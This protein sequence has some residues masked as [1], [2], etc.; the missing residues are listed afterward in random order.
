MAVITISREFG[1]AGEAIAQSVARQ[2]GYHLATK[3]TLETMVRG[4]GIVKFDEVYESVPTFWERL[5]S[6]RAEERENFIRLLNQSLAAL[7]RHGDTVILG[8]GGFSVL[9]G[10]ADVL[11]VRIQAPLSLRVSRT[12][13]LPAVVEPS[14]AEALVRG[15]DR[16]QEMFIESVYGVHWDSAKAFDVV[17]DTGKML[18]ELAAGLI[19]SIARAMK[20]PYGL[21]ARTTAQ[22]EVDSVLAATVQEVLDCHAAHVA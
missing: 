21:S 5:S 10:L 13:E 16:I 20:P 22:L 1:S 7:A 3:G 19:A 6:A 18:P 8:R 9:A 4:Y 12:Q 2:L 11:H 15:K 17:L 14:L